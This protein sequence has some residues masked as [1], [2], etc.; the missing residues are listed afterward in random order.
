MGKVSIE[1]PVPLHASVISQIY[2]PI[3]LEAEDA[4]A[5]LT[6][7]SEGKLFRLIC[8]FDSI[9][10]MTA[11]DFEGS[12][13]ENIVI[14][15]LPKYMDGPHVIEVRIFDLPSETLI[16]HAEVQIEVREGWNGG[17]LRDEMC[18]LC[19]FTTDWT[20]DHVSDWE[21]LLAG[22]MLPAQAHW[23]EEQNRSGFDLL[24]IGSWEGRC[25]RR[26][27]V[28][29]TFQEAQA[30]IEYPQAAGTPPRAHRTTHRRAVGRAAR[31]AGCGPT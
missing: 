6:N 8:T 2:D 13:E 29:R 15:P 16:E 9:V 23:S 20:K 22:F 25:G 27:H 24:E 18:P 11:F 7:F 5:R 12:A 10:N 17:Q 14:L 4:K 31:H 30:R 3:Q 19:E 1:L 21:T 26:A 28:F